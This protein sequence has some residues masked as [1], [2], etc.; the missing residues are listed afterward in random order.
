MTAKNI[1]NVLETYQKARS[2]FVQSINQLASRP[3]NAEY[4]LKGN[5]LELLTTLL[6]DPVPSI[7][8][9]AVMALAKL[10]D[11]NSNVASTIAQQGII[12]KIVN[13]FD[14]KTNYYKKSAA[15]CLKNIAK[16]NAELAEV[17]VQLGG[18]EVIMYCLES[19]DSSLKEAAACALASI[20]CH[21]AELARTVYKA[22]AI[23][24]LV[25]CLQEPEICLKQTAC[26]VLC[27]IAKH[28][29]DLAQSIVDAHATPVLV[30]LASSSN[31]NLKAQAYKTLGHISK[32][33]TELSEYVVGAE[34]LPQLLMDMGHP[35]SGVK[36]SACTLVKDIAKHNLQFAQLIVNLG[37][38]GVLINI[39]SENDEKTLLPAIV[40]IGY[41]AAHSDKFALALISSEVVQKLSN[42]LEK[43]AQDHI[44][45]VTVWTLGH[46]GRHSSEHARHLA[47]A[48][49]FATLIELMTSENS[50]EDLKGKC[51]STLRFTLQKCTDLS[52]LE[53][54]LHT[55]PV[56]IL[57]YILGQFSKILPHD[58]KARRLFAAS[59]SL[60]KIQEIEAE[61]GSTLMEY[62]TTIN[63]CYPE[64]IIRYFTPNYPDVLL[65]QLENYVP[66]MPSVLGSRT[67]TLDEPVE[68]TVITPKGSDCDC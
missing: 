42:I 7:Q 9:N 24:L 48:N 30:K 14:K 17:V 32:H 19:F 3:Q 60:K 62:I 26:L 67:K 11:L 46:L 35:D 23:P 16:H 2:S 63:E 37:G 15:T 45:A 27:E 47:Q 13:F 41:I 61:P 38:L 64:E 49:T 22:G 53:P 28:S 57:K 55:A 43:E 25:L 68:V 12:N 51:R 1:L 54:L 40:A 33:S 65:E 59:G 10:A 34:V 39:L 5:V 44:L 36:R 31:V 4:L 58:P 50:S 52:A 21:N 6:S 56:E 8:H 66:R 29:V 18:I 20:A